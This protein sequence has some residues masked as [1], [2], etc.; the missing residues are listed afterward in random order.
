MERGFEGWRIQGEK[1]ER[2]VGNESAEM[3]DGEKVGV[4]G[5]GV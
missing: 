3:G 5:E 1:V 2:S 4:R